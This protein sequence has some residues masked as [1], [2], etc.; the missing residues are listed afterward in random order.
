MITGNPFQSLP[1]TIP[2]RPVLN[3]RLLYRLPLHIRQ[4]I[5]AATFERHDVIHDVTFP[6]FRITS[7]FH[8]G[9][10]GSRAPLD[11]SVGAASGDGRLP[12]TRRTVGRGQP[13]CTLKTIGVPEN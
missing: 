2:L 11:L 12:W 5:G 13:C 10:A 1:S 4:N 9:M 3:L 6:T 8:K 7:L